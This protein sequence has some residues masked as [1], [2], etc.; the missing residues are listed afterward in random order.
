MTPSPIGAGVGAESASRP[1]A[2][3]T[4]AMHAAAPKAAVVGL[5]VMGFSGVRW[6][7]GLPGFN[8]FTRLPIP[9]RTKG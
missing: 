3:M 1:Q 7:V 8:Y 2:A 4:N 6:G 5:G 9:P